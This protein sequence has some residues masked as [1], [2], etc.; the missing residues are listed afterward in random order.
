M[1][2]DGGVQLT[3]RISWTTSAQNDFASSWRKHRCPYIFCCVL[4]H[5]STSHSEI[6][7]TM[8]LTEPNSRPFSKRLTQRIRWHTS[9]SIPSITCA[10]LYL[11]A[12]RRSYNNVFRRWWTVCTI[13]WNDFWGLNVTQRSY[14][15]AQILGS[16]WRKDW[17]CTPSWYNVMHWKYTL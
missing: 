16:G 10:C 1:P 2:F 5:C 9:L 3:R 14:L 8:S 7:C 13:L 6:A 15:D 4:V 17:S 12:D 11:I